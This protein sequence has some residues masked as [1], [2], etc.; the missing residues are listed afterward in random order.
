MR[1][2]IFSVAALALEVAERSIFASEHLAPLRLQHR[3]KLWVASTV[4]PEANMRSTT[5]LIE[6]HLLHGHLD[7]VPGHRERTLVDVRPVLVDVDHSVR[8]AFTL[9]SADHATHEAVATEATGHER[10]RSVRVDDM[11]GD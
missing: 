6:D 7:V 4:R 11:L 9:N 1:V 3:T 8:L 10:D 2:L 5:A